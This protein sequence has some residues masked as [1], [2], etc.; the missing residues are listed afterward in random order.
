MVWG[1]V[2]W[3]K[4]YCLHV[5]VMVVGGAVVYLCVCV[6]LSE[7]LLSIYMLE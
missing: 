5:V 4:V 7:G 1:G 3:G 2:A 6:G